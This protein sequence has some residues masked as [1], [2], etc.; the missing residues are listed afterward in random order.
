MWPDAVGTTLVIGRTRPTGVH[1][2]TSWTTAPTTLPRHAPA[3]AVLQGTS[4]VLRR[5]WLQHAEREVRAPDGRLAPRG[6]GELLRTCLVAA[7]VEAAH[8]HDDDPSAVGPA[9][10]ALWLALQERRGAREREAVGPVPPPGVRDLR[11][12]DLARWNDAPGRSH[13]D[14]LGLVDQAARRV[15]AELDR[16]GPASLTTHPAEPVPSAR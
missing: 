7:V 10:D 9:L 15:Q 2:R 8:R 3:L 6:P 1:V 12:R 13:E 11:A 5:G 4:A 16:L 14:V